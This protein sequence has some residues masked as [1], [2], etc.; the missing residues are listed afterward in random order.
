MFSP[1][2]QKSDILFFAFQWDSSTVNAQRSLQ[3][4]QHH[5]VPRDY[6]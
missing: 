1:L 5:Y 2:Q 3:Q 6:A 4:Q